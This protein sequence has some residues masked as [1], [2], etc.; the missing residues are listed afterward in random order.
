MVRRMD[1]SLARFLFGPPPAMRL[2][3]RVAD[4]LARQQRQSEILI[5]CIQA[6]LI[7]IFATLYLWAPQPQLVDVPFYPV[8]WA[9]G[10][11][12]GFTA[13][14]L[15]AAIRDRLPGWF[16]ALSILIDMALLMLMIWSFHLQYDAVP[17]FYLRSP[18][19]LYVFIFIA[20]R[21]FRYEPR[22]VLLAGVSAAAG[23][24]LLLGYVVLKATPD[25]YAD[26]YFEYMTSYKVLLAGEFDKVISILLVTGLLALALVRARRLL[27]RAVADGASAMELA[28]FFSPDVAAAIT[29]SE[30]TLKPGEGVER[31]AAALFVDLRGFTTLAGML[32]P[33]ALMGLLGEYHTRVIAA[34]R[35]NGGTINTFL[36][37]GVMASFGGT[38]S[39]A[40]FAA[41][42]FRTAEALIDSLGAW[43]AARRARGEAAPGIGIGI[44][45]GR[46]ICGAVGDEQRL[47]YATLG[48]AVNR[49]AKLQNHTKAEG[50]TA[51]STRATRDLARAQGYDGLRAEELRPL[52]A[53]AGIAS[54]VDLV[55]IA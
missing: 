42:A 9:L 33:R 43:S 34:V 7:G 52:R 54:P 29:G 31:E 19:L 27:G 55:V 51:L 50:V 26:D 32:E 25:L 28:R 40:T 15:A 6:V 35:A 38:R 48:D 5:G 4:N 45:A 39:S 44:D 47:E 11:Y 16:L 3:A 12:A 13:L 14:R 53:V 1:R 20:L 8:P 49:A 36:G 18:A 22:Y 21:M 23:W 37:D 17:A 30:E 10:F 2:P 24:L 41:D 46:M